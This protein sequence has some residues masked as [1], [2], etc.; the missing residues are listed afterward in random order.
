MARSGDGLRIRNASFHEGGGE[1]EEETENRC[2]KEIAGS[3]RERWQRHAGWMSDITGHDIWKVA[4]RWDAMR[5]CELESIYSPAKP[6]Q[7]T[8]CARKESAVLRTVSDMHFV[9]RA[10]EALDRQRNRVIIYL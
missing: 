3:V 5:L 2:Q 6:P 9:R 1:G 8:H 7:S 10:L 4:L